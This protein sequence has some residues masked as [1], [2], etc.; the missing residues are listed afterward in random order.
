MPRR[1]ATGATT[2]AITF[3]IGPGMGK[4]LVAVLLDED[5]GL[6]E[7]GHPAGAHLAV[8]RE[9]QEGLEDDFGPQRRAELDREMGRLARGASPVVLYAR[10]DHRHVSRLER[11]GRTADLAH[12][13]SRDHFDPLL[14]ARVGVLAEDRRVGCHERV[15]SQGLAAGVGGGRAVDHSQ[16]QLLARDLLAG[17]GH[18]P[19]SLS[20]WTRSPRGALEHAWRGAMASG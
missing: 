12:E 8:G 15:E 4:R 3:L 2:T 6:E 17:V 19:G 14:L 16:A 20:L 10:G 18:Q 1:R 5:R 9:S 11:L 7:A 13:P